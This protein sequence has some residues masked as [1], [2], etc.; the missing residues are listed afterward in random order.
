MA[1]LAHQFDPGLGRL[2]QTGPDGVQ[3]EIDLAGQ[4]PCW[5]QDPLAAE[6]LLELPA[7]HGIFG[8]YQ[9]IRCDAARNRYYA[10]SESR[11]DGQAAGN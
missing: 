1:K 9:A 11:K 7:L 6:P 4:N 2:G 3:I 8:G 10:A 5:I